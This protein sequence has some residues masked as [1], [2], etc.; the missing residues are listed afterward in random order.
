[1]NAIWNGQLLQGMEE[2]ADEEARVIAGGES[3]SFWIG[4]AAGAV[5]NFFSHVSPV[6]S[7]GQKLM[8]ASLG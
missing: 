6:Q 7:G 3:L 4:Y 1:M 8:N 5:V 2:L